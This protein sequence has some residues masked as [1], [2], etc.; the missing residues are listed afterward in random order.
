M[1]GL[2]GRQYHVSDHASDHN[3]EDA[4]EASG[5]EALPKKHMIPLSLIDD[6]SPKSTG[7]FSED[8]CSGTFAG[9]SSL[10]VASLAS[11]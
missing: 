7:P 10:A 2:Q 3:D 8:Q 11:Q 5:D 4:S 6:A 1:C 9:V